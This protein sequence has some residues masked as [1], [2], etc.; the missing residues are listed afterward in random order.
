MDPDLLYKGEYYYKSGVNDSMR[1]A[2]KDVVENALRYVE[3][4]DF[5]SVIDIGSNDGTLLS[6]YLDTINK[7]AFEPSDAYIADKTSNVIIHDF[8][9]ADSVIYDSLSKVKIITACAMFYDLNDP[10]A[11]LKDV[12]QVLADDGVFI[13]QMNYL[14]SMVENCNFDN[15]SHEHLCYYSLRDME[16]LLAR[17]NMYV[18]D[19]EL[20][21]VNGGSIRLYIRKGKGQ[22]TQRVQGLRQGENQWR[23][24]GAWSSEG[25][26]MDIIY[27]MAIQANSIK[28]NLQRAL[29]GRK[30]CALGAS[31]RGYVIL[32]YLGLEMDLIDRNPE[33]V[34]KSLGNMPILSEDTLDGYDCALI[35]PYH[36][37]SEMASRYANYRGELITPIPEVRM[38]PRAHAMV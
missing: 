5:D 38:V 23:I 24:N 37:A 8:F 15:I 32:Q 25:A 14:K 33:K 28:M 26:M 16:S 11:F 18:Q 10:L 9:S 21:G 7:V 29:A 35:L 6:N 22:Y 20:N 36:F 3:L 4:K 13:V 1:A 2:L 19:A 17:V 31:T 34:G 30:V 27:K 12:A